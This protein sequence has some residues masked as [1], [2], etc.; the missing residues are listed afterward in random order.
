MVTQSDC[1][2]S[3]PGQR[4]L[5][6]M[7][8]HS[9]RPGSPRLL[10]GDPDRFSV[11]ISYA[12]GRQALDAL[13]ATFRARRYPFGQF[14][15]F[16]RPVLEKPLPE[17]PRERAVFWFCLC[18]WMRGRIESY[19]ALWRLARVWHHDR[20][21]FEPSLWADAGSPERERLA[22][23]LKREGLSVGVDKYHKHDWHQNLAK[24]NRFW[25]GD[26]RNLV[27]GA[28]TFKDLLVRIQNRGRFS[29][30]KPAGF[31]GFQRKMVAMLAHFLS[32]D[33]LVRAEEFPFPV[34]IHVGR[35]L[36]YQRAIEVY[37]EL[38]DGSRRIA[39]GDWDVR[40]ED[41]V[42]PA[43]K[44]CLRY[45]AEEKAG[46]AELGDA[47]WNFA[48]TM[49]AEAPQNRWLLKSRLQGRKTLLSPVPVTASNFARRRFIQTCS[50]C[51]VWE[52][53]RGGTIGTAPYFYW[54]L[55]SWRASANLWELFPSIPGL[56]VPPDWPMGKPARAWRRIANGKGLG[57]GEWLERAAHPKIERR[58][59]S[60]HQ[61][62]LTI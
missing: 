46:A 59:H 55:F 24:L 57:P 50:A 29:S 10:P 56:H 37:E 52:S 26:P 2:L 25:G 48:G 44:L 30:D 28:R 60:H 18:F 8:D 62:T 11:R 45:M 43:I 34:D 15:P 40:Y 32:T 6:A 41:V 13:V 23:A 33:D 16:V 38:P 35:F 20:E 4:K 9:Q 17:D 22:K 5:A 27:F 1:L 3:S 58:V 7:T 61:Q 12:R 36:L 21:L 31:R 19:E 47:V 49:C 51:P 39:R 53:C 54:G 42:G 14:V